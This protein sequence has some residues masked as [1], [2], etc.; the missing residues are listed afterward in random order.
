M[1]C[2]IYITKSVLSGVILK[3]YL[4]PLV[5]GRLI[6]FFVGGAPR[7]YSF[8][9]EYGLSPGLFAYTHGKERVPVISRP[10]FVELV[11]NYERKIAS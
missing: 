11:R 5:S 6:R 7:F 8:A 10:I 3:P 4:R 9:G 1:I 2:R